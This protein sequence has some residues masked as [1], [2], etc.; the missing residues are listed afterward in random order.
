MESEIQRI[1]RGKKTPP[2]LERLKK[3]IADE[4]T[5]PKEAIKCKE[6]LADNASPLHARLHLCLL[7]RSSKYK[8]SVLKLAE[9]YKKYLEG[10]STQYSD[11]MHNTKYGLVFLLAKEYDAQKQYYGFDV[12]MMLSNGVIRYFLELCEQAFDFA[13]DSGFN[14]DEPCEIS[15]EDQT[16]AARYVSRY[17][18]KDIDGYEP[19]GRVLRIFVH[20]IGNLFRELHRNPDTTL[21]EPEPNHFSLNGFTIDE[22]TKLVLDSAVMWGVLQERTPTKEKDVARPVEIFD[23]HLN[24]IYCPFY[25]ISYRKKRKITFSS[26]QFNKL[27]SG[28]ED[29]SKSAVREILSQ[30]KGDK[31]RNLVEQ[32]SIFDGVELID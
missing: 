13:M 14:W 32:L 6:L 8:P 12:F 23:Y 9:E 15:P 26:E 4:V 19:F 24:R 16:K 1:I 10:K 2:F 11:W 22:K 27:M 30:K 31:S 21:G 29:L 3:I 25:E 5:E 28:S 17:K 18:I 7:L 20:Q